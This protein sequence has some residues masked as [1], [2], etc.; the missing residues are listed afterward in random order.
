MA[1]SRL[2]L[3][4]I[5]SLSGTI[6]LVLALFLPIYGPPMGYVEGTL[7]PVVS[8]ITITEQVP[9]DDGLG[10]LIRFTYTKYR[11]CASG[12]S[13]VLHIGANEVDF[14]LVLPNADPL[15][16]LP[17]KQRSSQWYVGSPTL[18]GA[19]IWFVHKCGPFW[20][21]ITKVYG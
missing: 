20:L 3:N 16:R 6:L 5:G 15:V 8:P 19:E 17:G 10:L 18:E 7:L 14:H 21:T 9:T 13:P 11:A 4:V 1:F 12:S 2:S